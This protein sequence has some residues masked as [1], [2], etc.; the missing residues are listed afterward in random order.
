ELRWLLWEHR[1]RQLAVEHSG[2]FAA[3]AEAA[4]SLGNGIE[5]SRSGPAGTWKFDG[6]SDLALVPYLYLVAAS[7]REAV[8]AFVEALPLPQVE[9][10]TL[11]LHWLLAHGERQEALAFWNAREAEADADDVPQSVRNFL[12][13]R[14]WEVFGHDSMDA[15]YLERSRILQTNQTGNLGYGKAYLASDDVLRILSESPQSLLNSLRRNL[16]REHGRVTAEQLQALADRL[17]DG[18]GEMPLAVSQGAKDFAAKLEPNTYPWFM[19]RGEFDEAARFAW[20]KLR[21]A[22]GETEY[23][24]WAKRT[25]EAVMCREQCYN[26]TARDFLLWLNGELV[27]ADGKPVQA[28]PIAE[29]LG[30]K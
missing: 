10:F 19:F 25:A 27:D 12:F 13:I 29:V 3:F 20:G 4:K 22:E 30:E 26:G 28:N 5:F 18:Q 24:R 21:E 14:K 11:Q 6:G 7:E 2:D 9:R 17:I 1:A 15:A 16:Q 8:F 23:S